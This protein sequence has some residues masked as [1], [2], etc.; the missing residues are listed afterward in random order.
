MW[1]LLYSELIM[2]SA[3]NL[4]TVTISNPL[5]M[6]EMWRML[7]SIFFVIEN[8]IRDDFCLQGLHWCYNSY[9]CY[10]MLHKVSC[11][12]FTTKSF[13][14]MW[15]LYNY[16]MVFTYFVFIPLHVDNLYY[17]W[18]L[19]MFSLIIGQ[20]LMK[21]TPTKIIIGNWNNNSIFSVYEHLNCIIYF[22][23][24]CKLLLC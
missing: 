20:K 10:I 5:K 15:N 1:F 16:L 24:L 9:C 7:K 6:I 4:I 11:I 19:I 18:F 23:T 3:F 2:N 13:I 17:N 12:T 8:I 21:K 22:T 14:F